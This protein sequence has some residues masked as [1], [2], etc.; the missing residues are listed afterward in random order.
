MTEDIA[1]K[2]AF[3]QLIVIAGLIWKGSAVITELKEAIKHEREARTLLASALEKVQI[4]L[5]A[6]NTVPLHELRIKTLEDALGATSHRLDSVWRKVF[7]LDRHVAVVR[8]HSS[9]DIADS[10]PPPKE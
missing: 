6:L 5:A 10:D 7:S 1:I 8:A 3:G 9:H 2:I 4:G